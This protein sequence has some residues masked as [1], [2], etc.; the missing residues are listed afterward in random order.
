MRTAGARLRTLA[1]GEVGERRDWVAHIIEKLREHPDVELVSDGGY[2]SYD[3]QPV[4]KVR[5]GHRLAGD[6]LELGHAARAEESYEAFS[7]LRAQHGLD[8]VAFQVG[9]PSDL[10]IALFSFGPAGAFRRRGAFR[11]ALVREISEIAAWAGDD[12]VFQIECPAELVMIA[13][14]PPPLRPALARMLARP[15]M[16]LVTAAPPGSRFGVHLCVGDLQNRALRHLS[17]TGPIAAFAKALVRAWPRDRRLEFL[18]LPFASGDRPA[19]A[20]ARFYLPL[21]KLRGTPAGPRIVAGLV[22]ESQ[23]L[24]D[25]RVVLGLVE[26]AVGRVVDVGPSCGLGRRTPEVAQTV[27]SRAVAIADSR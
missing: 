13:S 24:A 12:G 18:H 17:D 7:G 3:D 26:A 8:G 23:S 5:K 19:P 6:S 14:A 15:L 20:D 10:D 9:I 2:T 11:A 16:R 21:R 25:Q 22:H 4:F 27:L 1:D